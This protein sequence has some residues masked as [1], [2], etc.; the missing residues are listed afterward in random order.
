MTTQ[1]VTGNVGRMGGKMI[2]KLILVIVFA[3]YVSVSLPTL[4]ISIVDPFDHFIVFYCL[5]SRRGVICNTFLFF[6]QM[7]GLQ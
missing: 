5:S 3:V 6:V 7:L 4:V 1:L 2:L